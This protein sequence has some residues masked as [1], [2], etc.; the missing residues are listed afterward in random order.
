MTPPP[1]EKGNGLRRYVEEHE[2]LVQVVEVPS[3]LLVE[4]VGKLGL[5]V[6]LRGDTLIVVHDTEGITIKDTTK[7]TSDGHSRTAIATRRFA[8]NFTGRG[9]GI[10]SAR[11]LPERDTLGINE[12]GVLV[13]ERIG[14]E[15]NISG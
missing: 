5:R 14:L 13:M 3:V 6:I 11:T 7:D 2:V 12:F 1:R 10:V 9:K 4:V 8:V 15:V